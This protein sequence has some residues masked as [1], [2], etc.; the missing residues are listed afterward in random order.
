MGS[1]FSV[2]LPIKEMESVKIYP[3]IL[4]VDYDAKFLKE[5]KTHFVDAKTWMTRPHD[6]PEDII[7]YLED[8]PEVDFLIAEIK[9]PGMDGWT[10]FE[11]IRKRFPLLCVIL[12][13][14]DDKALQIPQD[15]LQTD[16]LLKK[17]FQFNELQKIIHEIGRQR[18]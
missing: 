7:V 13:S 12:Y 2:F 10:L 14:C 16:Y 9:Q 3:S 18:L 15:T 17:P 5:I 1:R 6:R 4:C 8:H 11:R